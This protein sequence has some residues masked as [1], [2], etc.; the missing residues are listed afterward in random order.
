[1]QF[2]GGR[3]EKVAAARPR[4]GAAAKKK[5][6]RRADADSGVHWGFVR[7]CRADYSSSLVM[8]GARLPTTSPLPS[9]E[10]LRTKLETFLLQSRSPVADATK[11]AAEAMPVLV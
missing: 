6:P 1:M 3:Q 7:R 10:P 2:S 9:I 5:K 11:V 8:I 4:N